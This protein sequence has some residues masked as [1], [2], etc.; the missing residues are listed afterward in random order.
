MSLALLIDQ[1]TGTHLASWIHPDTDEAAST[2]IDHFR[3]VAQLAEHGKFDMFFV[4]DTPAARTENL[5]AWR[6]FP[7]YMNQLEPV[8]LLAALSGQR[9]A[10]ASVPQSRRASQSPTT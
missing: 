5:H 1:A 3:R 10:S 8:T 6:R 4:A 9:R 7:M 2:K